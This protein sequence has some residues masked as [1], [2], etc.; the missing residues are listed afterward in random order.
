MAWVERCQRREV[1]ATVNGVSQHGTPA[2]A[3]S[4]AQPKRAGALVPARLPAGAAGAPGAMW[5]RGAARPSLRTLRQEVG[6]WSAVARVGGARA[7]ELCTQGSSGSWSAPLHPAFHP[8]TRLRNKIENCCL[9]SASDCQCSAMGPPS[10]AGCGGERLPPSVRPACESS[11]E[12]ASAKRDLPGGNAAAPAAPLGPPPCTCLHAG[13]GDAAAPP[14]APEG[15]E[16]ILI[17][18]PFS[19]LVV[20]FGC[21]GLLRRPP[22]RDAAW[23]AGGFAMLEVRLGALRD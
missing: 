23:A 5:R 14:R 11:C 13:G 2:R 4:A 15:E 12:R 3:A 22:P 10:P 16:R 18:R 20:P 9:R 17:S 7:V 6:L 19:P 21:G 8:G 1:E